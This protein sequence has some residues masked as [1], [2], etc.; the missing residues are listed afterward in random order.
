MKISIRHEKLYRFQKIDSWDIES[1]FPVRFV[2]FWN[3]LSF[4]ILPGMPGFFRFSFSS[5]VF[6]RFFQCSAEN[7]HLKLFRVDAYYVSCFWI[8]KSRSKYWRTNSQFCPHRWT[9]FDLLNVSWQICYQPKFP[10][11]F[12]ATSLNDWT[13]LPKSDIFPLVFMKPR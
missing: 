3:L 1:K 13:F 2:F 10:I 12:L 8:L 4:C 11:V 9:A 7:R 6:D 5:P